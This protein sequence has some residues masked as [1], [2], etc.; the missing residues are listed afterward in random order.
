[1]LHRLAT[2]DSNE[3]TSDWFLLNMKFCI[4]N[5]KVTQKIQNQCGKSWVI[6][7]IVKSCNEKEILYRKYQKIKAMK[8]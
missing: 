6:N 1:M 5:E 2:S 7:A 3:G 4:N 8:M